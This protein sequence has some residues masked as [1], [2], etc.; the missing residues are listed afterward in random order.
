[1]KYLIDGLKKYLQFRGRTSR[2]AF[3]MFHLWMVILSFILG[4]FFAFTDTFFGPG[5]ADIVARTIN[6]F[7]IL[8]MISIAVRRLHDIGRSGWWLLALPV[9]L[10]MMFF[11]SSPEANQYGPPSLAIE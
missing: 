4:F 3:W 9:A 11:R 7:L 2:K 5:F 1:M 8:P 6:I 10:I